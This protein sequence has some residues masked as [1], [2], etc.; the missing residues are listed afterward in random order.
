MKKIYFFLQQNMPRMGVVLL[1]ILP[2]C[3]CRPVVSDE[4]AKPPPPVSV[5]V[6]FR[7]APKQSSTNRLAGRLSSLQERTVEYVDSSLNRT[8][9]IPRNIGYDTLTLPALSGYAEIWHHNQVIDDIPYLLMAGDTVLFTYDKNLRPQIRSL[10]SDNNTWLYNLPWEDSRA[11]QPVGYS[12]ARVLT[13]IYYRRADE[14]VHHPQKKYPAG[15]LAKVKKFQINLDSLRPIYTS[16][17]KDF[18]AK[19]DS[20]ENTG[21]LPAIY[22]DYY[23][24]YPLYEGE[25]PGAPPAADSLLQYISHYNNTIHYQYRIAP[26]NAKSPARFDLIASDTVLTEKARKIVL[27]DIMSKIEN[28]D[29]VRSYPAEV[30]KKYRNLYREITGDTS[31]LVQSI[32][33]ENLVSPDGYST[34]LV[35]EGPDGLQSDYGALLD[36]H[37]GKVVYIDLWASWCAPCRAGMPAA[38]KLREQYKEKDVV[39]IYLAVKDTKEAWQ[40]AVR[41]LETEY[42]AE[43]YRILNAGDSKFMSE[44]KHSRLPH[45][46]LYDRNGKLVD[47]DAPRPDDTTINAEI[48]KLLK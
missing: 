16:Y 25:L 45:M 36:R 24:K 8:F 44:I 29:Y 43:N 15:F 14:V 26:A 37:K 35:L 27:H 32:N 12:T 19:L 46:L 34:D 41:S 11:I 13:D 18:A 22:A 10:V 28:G 1:L 7:D 48:D 5:T 40:G 2:I 38:K 3:A 47:Y 23:R 42:L 4:N 21:R 6:I 39:F 31:F 30:I 20:L 33:K 9:Y 17:L